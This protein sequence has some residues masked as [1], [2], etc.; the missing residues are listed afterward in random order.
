MSRSKVGKKVVF[1]FMSVVLTVGLMPLPAYAGD[2]G[3]GLAAGTAGALGGPV[4]PQ[5]G[6]ALVIPLP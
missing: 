6:R 3:G 1:V 2:A 4:Q 5:E